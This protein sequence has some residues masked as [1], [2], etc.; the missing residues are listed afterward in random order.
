MTRAVFQ[1]GHKTMFHYVKSVTYNACF[2]AGLLAELKSCHRIGCNTSTD[3]SQY[4]GKI[5]I[6]SCAGFNM[7]PERNDDTIH[8]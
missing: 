3:S 2:P 8:I 1:L 4:D 5:L 6:Q 7:I